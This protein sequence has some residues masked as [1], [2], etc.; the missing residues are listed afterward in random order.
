L[1]IA[2]I[3]VDKKVRA[4]MGQSRVAARFGF[5]AFARRTANSHPNHLP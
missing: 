5:K 1:L 2:P 3:H 4:G